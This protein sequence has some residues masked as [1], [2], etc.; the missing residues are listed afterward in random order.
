VEVADE[1][2]SAV[3]C[4]RMEQVSPNYGD[5]MNAEQQAQ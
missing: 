3:C 4:C 1:R 2:T 5:G